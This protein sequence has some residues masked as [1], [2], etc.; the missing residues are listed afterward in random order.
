MRKATEKTI[1]PR[2]WFGLFEPRV[3][4]RRRAHALLVLAQYRVADDT[5]FIC[6]A[7]ED[8]CNYTKDATAFQLRKI[9]EGRLRTSGGYQFGTYQAWYEHENE[10]FMMDPLYAK[11]LRLRWLDALIE[12]FKP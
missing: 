6:F 5:D 10:V 9:I 3:K 2:R 1:P 8:A 12:E 7:L 11:K 4:D